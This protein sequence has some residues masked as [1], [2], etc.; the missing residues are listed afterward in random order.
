MIRQRSF[1]VYLLLNFV[2][3][4]IYGLY[5]WYVWNEDVNRI[6]AGDG[7]EMPNYIVVVLLGIITCG[8]YIFY[9]MYKQGNR[10]QAN[11][12]RYGVQIQEN[13]STFLLWALLGLITCSLAQYYGYYLMIQAVNRI[14][15]GYNR[16]NGLGE[17]Y[18]S[19]SYAGGYTGPYAGGYTGGYA[20]EDYPQDDNKQN[21]FYMDHMS[22]Q[23]SGQGQIICICGPEISRITRIQ[24]AQ[25]LILGQDGAV[26]NHIIMGNAIEAKHCSITYRKW[27]NTYLVTDYS[28]GGTFRADNDQRL[29]GSEMTEFPAGTVIYLGDRATMY[30]L[31]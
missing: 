21:D 31:G 14:A 27:D 22:G 26:C 12:G 8:I 6:C 16:A 15:P 4:G 5:F 20:R 24:D 1:W 9:W 25:T 2:T 13:G 7:Q 17:D 29:P 3:C 10:L 11:A 18:T 28:I 30:R 19:G 23:T